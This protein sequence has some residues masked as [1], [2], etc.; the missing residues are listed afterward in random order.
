[1]NSMPTGLSGKQ[2]AHYSLVRRGR[3][4]HTLGGCCGLFYFVLYNSARG[5]S[6]LDLLDFLVVESAQVLNH[7]TV[8]TECI[9]SLLFSL[10]FPHVTL[11][12]YL[13]RIPKQNRSIDYQSIVERVKRE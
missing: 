5:R 2:A 13:R 3:D 9:E 7:A 12:R 10:A 11:N 6:I 8:F 1:M 4:L